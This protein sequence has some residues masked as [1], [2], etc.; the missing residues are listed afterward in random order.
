M[1][2][3]RIQSCL[4]D[5]DRS[6]AHSS[7]GLHQN[8]LF[9]N[10]CKILSPCCGWWALL[11]LN[12]TRSNDYRCATTALPCL[13]SQPCA[14]DAIMAWKCFIYKVKTCCGKVT[15]RLLTTCQMPVKSGPPWIAFQRCDNNSH[16]SNVPLD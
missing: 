13:T 10:C 7:L 1:S 15:Y 14:M 9:F 8:A 6:P 11:S 5:K 4:M 2:G 16:A 3:F 12:V